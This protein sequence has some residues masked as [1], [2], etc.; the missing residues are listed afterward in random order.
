MNRKF[1][2]LSIIFLAQLILAGC[3]SFNYRVANNYYEQYAYSKAIPKYEAVLRKDFIPEA[4]ANL[5]NSYSKTG[6]SMK[7]EIWYQRLVKSPNVKIDYKLQLAETLM[8]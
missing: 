5:A 8:E 3:K 1:G 6:N 4:A 7:A 2:F